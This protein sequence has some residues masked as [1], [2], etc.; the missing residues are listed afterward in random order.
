MS[1]A[2]GKN[3]SYMYYFFFVIKADDN[4]KNDKAR[5]ATYGLYEIPVS[6]L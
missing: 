5:T 6:R 2:E 3:I 4:N 1:N